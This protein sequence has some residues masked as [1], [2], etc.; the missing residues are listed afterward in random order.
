MALITPGQVREHYPALQ[1]TAEDV[2]LATLIERADE[3]MA[4]YCGFPRPAGAGTRRTLED[5]S[6]V[7]YVDGPR[8]DVPR[9][10]DLPVYPVVSVESVHVDELWAYDAAT[11]V[12]P[13]QYTL[14]PETG[15][16]YLTATATVAWVSAP[17]A[18]RVAY[19]AGFA[20]TPP[21]L[22]AI[23]AAAV[24]HLLDSGHGAGLTSLSAGGTST[25][26]PEDLHALPPTV[27]AAL[28]AGY[29]L[30]GSRV[31]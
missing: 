15:E 26:R 25:T 30:W 9:L 4:A 21:G 10:L 24:R 13:A 5:A 8:A 19:T 14:V 22:V 17:R 29:T 20:A 28:D 12:D 23:A 18:Q 6:Y 1:G 16:L 3:L 11:L 27:R 7:S 2:R 31:G